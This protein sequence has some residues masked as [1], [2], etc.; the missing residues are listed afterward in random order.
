MN[1]FSS[2]RWRFFL[3]GIGQSSLAL[4]DNRL[5]TVLSIL[6]IT[7][8]IA[9]VMAI[10]TVSKGGHFLVLN[11]LRT[12]GL[13]SV[14][15]YRANAEKDPNRIVRQ[16]T[17]IEVGDL[18][19]L[20]ASC[21][22]AVRRISPL[23]YNIGQ[24]RRVIRVGNR[25]S[26]AEVSG[27]GAE[28]AAI[29]NDVLT[30]GYFLRTEDVARRRAVAVIGTTAR[31]D[32]FGPAADPIGKEF[33][34]GDKKYTVIGLLEHK[35]R[36]FL[37][38]IRSIEDANNRILL[39]YTTFHVLRG[40][41]DVHAVQA[42]ATEPE[43]ADLAVAQI[44]GVLDRLHNRRF[45]YKSET[46][47]TYIGT[48]DRILRGVSL[49]GILAASISLLVG[50][51]GIMNVV[52]NSVLERTK[53]IGLRKA[54]GASQAHIMFQFLMESVIISTIGGV[55]GLTLGAVLS[56]ILTWV[57]GLPLIP[58]WSLVITALVVSIMVGVLSGYYPARRAARLRPVIA[59]RYE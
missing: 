6:G 1:I 17:G 27:V 30:A 19:V 26:N 48:T 42:E 50:G 12:F 9:A 34:I 54:I 23:V 33:H 47:E 28:F 35:K 45:A 36:D 55:L 24:V 14:W 2:K 29:N 8:G 5:R 15:I 10:G 49:I 20:G 39:P 11:E 31:D 44:T 52:S 59:L 32:L 22:S 46:M 38:S 21:C 7:I 16:G 4:K 58:S 25:F 3:D 18:S 37:A 43:Y 51:M 40:N 41:Q 57:T 13:N 53:E 56:L